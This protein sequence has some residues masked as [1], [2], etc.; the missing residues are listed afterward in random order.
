MKLSLR[1]FK[2]IPVIMSLIMN[3]TI[4]IAKLNFQRAKLPHGEKCYGRGKLGKAWKPLT[5][6]D[7]WSILL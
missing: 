2:G 1:F 6:W 5:P 3:A 7:G 4:S